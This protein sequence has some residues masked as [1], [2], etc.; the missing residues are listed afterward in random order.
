MRIEFMT[1]FK[2]GWFHFDQFDTFNR[3]AVEQMAS[4]KL[5]I[6]FHPS[7]ISHYM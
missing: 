7:N 4:E 5:Q 2:C 1:G 6:I 3:E